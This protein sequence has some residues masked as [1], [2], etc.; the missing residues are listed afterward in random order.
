MQKKMHI[1]KNHLA[2]S[3][4]SHSIIKSSSGLTRV[5]SQSLILSR[6]NSPQQ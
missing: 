3:R 1:L 4:S 5:Q 2:D 6:A